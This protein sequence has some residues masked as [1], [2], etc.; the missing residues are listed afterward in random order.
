MDVPQVMPVIKESRPLPYYDNPPVVETVLGV[1]FDRLSGFKNGHLGAFWMSLG[2]DEWPVVEDAPPLPPQFE[3]FDNT[4]RWATGIHLQ[5]TQDPA[6]RLQ[7]KNQKADRMIQLQNNRLHF[8][9]LGEAGGVVST[10]RDSASRFRVSSTRVRGL[11][12][13]TAC[14]VFSTESMG[15]DLRQSD[16]PGRHLEH[17]K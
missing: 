8:N 11:C 1:Q 5:L 13:A 2:A 6:C 4:A 17:T 3:R 7:I 16:S 10:I 15:S 12:G 14:R 9:W